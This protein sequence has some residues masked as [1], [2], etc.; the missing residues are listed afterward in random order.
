MDDIRKHIDKYWD[1]IQAHRIWLHQHPEASGKETM[2][3]AYIA[4]ALREIGLKPREHVG[5]NG[6][7]AVIEG[8]GDCKGAVSNTGK[9]DGKNADGH[10]TDKY[11]NRQ[12]DEATCRH[13]DEG[14]YKCVALRAD[15]DALEVEEV[16]DFPY[17]SQ[18]PGMMHACGHDAHEIGRASCRERV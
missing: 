17:P 8:R 18:I 13:A 7:V 6:V 9:S 14:A 16:S 3:A 5:G 11:A 2:T 15:F 4:E 1:K 12:V 10:A